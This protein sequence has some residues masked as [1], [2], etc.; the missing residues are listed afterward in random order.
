MC[1]CT[2]SDDVA[3]ILQVIVITG[4]NKLTAEAICRQIGV[5]THDE[6]VTGKSM[7]GRNFTMLSPDKQRAVLMVSAPSWHYCHD[8]SAAYFYPCALERSQSGALMRLG[9]R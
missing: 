2:T 7:T 4:D 8:N 3:T 5:F 1:G 6:D 9:C